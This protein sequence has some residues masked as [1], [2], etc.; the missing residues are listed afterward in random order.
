MLQLETIPCLKDNYAFV[1][2]DPASG[3]TAVVDVPEAGPILSHLQQRNWKLTDI[4]LT[5]HHWDHID[6]VPDLVAATQAKI[7]G[8]AADAHRLPPLDRAVAEGDVFHFGGSAVD[9]FD[10]S[11]HT[12]GHIAYYIRNGGFLFSGDSLMAAGCGRLFEGTPDMM[13]KS[14]QKLAD[15]PDETVVCSGHEYTA[16]NLRFALTLE[17]DNPAL[18]SRDAAVRSA[19]DLG[20]ATVPSILSE[21]RATNPF[22]RANLPSMKA[23]LGMENASDEASFGEIRSRKDR[24]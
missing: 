15:L 2:H 24:F 17:P 6:G 5:H 10:V 11:G 12:V 16:S 23:A 7:T 1:I 8:A 14:L 22:L 4:F 20:R 13:W 18:I 21:E 19:R 3:A 9:V